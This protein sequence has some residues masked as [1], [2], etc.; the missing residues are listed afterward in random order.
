MQIVMLGLCER[1]EGMLNTTTCKK[2]QERT[3][4]E[5]RWRREEGFELCPAV[6]MP[7]KED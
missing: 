4:E 1:G 5:A 7:V 2:L 6:L 3:D